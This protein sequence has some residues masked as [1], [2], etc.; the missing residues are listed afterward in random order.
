M[1]IT[2]MPY[3]L[4]TTVTTKPSTESV[5]IFHDIYFIKFVLPNLSHITY[6][7]L[8]DGILDKINFCIGPSEVAS[9]GPAQIAL[10]NS[11]YYHLIV[12]AFKT[13]SNH[14]LCFQVAHPAMAFSLHYNDV[15][16]GSEIVSNHQPRHCLLSRLFGADQRKH[17][18][19]TSLAFVRGIHRGPVNFPHKW[20]VTR[21]MYSFEDVIML[22][23]DLPQAVQVPVSWH[24]TPE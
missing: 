8:Y 2:W 12:C 18:S 10:P 17:Q 15:I 22:T 11:H 19:S 3:E 14:D 9:A 4:N 23:L 6:P 16:M 13:Y 5:C 21:K 7:C 24:P 20:P 1:Q